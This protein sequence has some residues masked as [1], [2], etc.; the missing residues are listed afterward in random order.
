MRLEDIPTDIRD[1]AEIA[2][3]A[4]FGAIVTVA[5]GAETGT[6]FNASWNFHTQLS[7]LFGA[8]GA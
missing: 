1:A 4:A 7:A 6:V 8:A 2:G 3:W 5:T